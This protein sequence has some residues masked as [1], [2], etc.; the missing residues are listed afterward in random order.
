LNDLRDNRNSHRAIN[1][2]DNSVKSYYARK[3]YFSGAKSQQR[4]ECV[5]QSI[6]WLND[7][8]LLDIVNT[9][10]NGRVYTLFDNEMISDLLIKDKATYK[11]AY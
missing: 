3:L 2:Y 8:F 7:Y 1:Y 10:P 11:I 4:K 6:L 9:Q 5:L